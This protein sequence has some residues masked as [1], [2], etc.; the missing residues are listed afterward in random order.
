MTEYEFLTA[1]GDAF[2]FAVQA[3]MA[4]FTVFGAYVVTAYLAGES[5]SKT[6]AVSLSTLYTLFLTGPVSGIFV[7]VYERARLEA[8]YF[9]QYPEGQIVQEGLPP[10]VILVV[11]VGPLV[12]GWVL[13]LAYMHGYV[14][15]AP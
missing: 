3:A 14:R 9:R 2:S 4:F 1:I 13:S 7:N 11:I 6:V 12:I 5:F 15:R 10:S 8:L